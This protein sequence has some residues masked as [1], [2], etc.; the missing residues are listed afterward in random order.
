M[1][2]SRG[3]ILAAAV[4][5]LL[6]TA[7]AADAKSA[8]K[9]RVA[10]PAATAA[11][12]ACSSGSGVTGMGGMGMGGGA[13]AGAGLQQGAAPGEPFVLRYFDEIDTDRNQQLSR[14]EIEAWVKQARAQL[15]AQIKERF[16]AADTNADGQLSMDEARLGAPRL[17]E[18]FAF[19]DANQ[20][21]ML[22]LGELQQLGDRDLMRQRILER[23]RAAD[24]DG[25]GKLDLAEVQAAFPGMAAN[26]ALLDRDHDGYL[27]PDDFAGL[28]G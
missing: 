10:L 13:G 20:D 9:K 1:T 18:H 15:A 22:T 14:A 26:F 17:Y 24:R 19:V 5:A 4:A 8:K 12:P 2:V 23:V 28:G 11:A 7:A 25:N 21:G 3:L 6:M 27:T 16:V